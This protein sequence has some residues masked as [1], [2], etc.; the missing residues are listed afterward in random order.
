MCITKF[1]YF[2][3]SFDEL[4]SDSAPWSPT[5]QTSEMSIDSN[6]QMVDEPKKIYYSRE[7]C[8]HEAAATGGNG[9][10]GKLNTA[11]FSYKD[12]IRQKSARKKQEEAASR[13]K[14]EEDVSVIGTG[15]TSAKSIIS[16]I[17]GQNQYKNRSS[18]LESSSSTHTDT[19]TNRVIQ[20][21]ED[22]RR[23]SSP[24]VLDESGV[25]TASL[26]IPV[27]T[28]T[29]PFPLNLDEDI[30]YIDVFEQNGRQQLTI[31]HVKTPAAPPRRQRSI[32]GSDSSVASTVQPITRTQPLT[33]GSDSAFGSSI[34]VSSSMQN[35]P[36]SVSSGA[37]GG[38][39]SSTSSWAST[40]PTS[41]DNTQTLS[42]LP[43]DNL[44]LKTVKTQK[45]SSLATAQKVSFSATQELQQFKSKKS[46]KE[47][48][49]HKSQSAAALEQLKGASREP[50]FTPSITSIGN[51]VIRSKTA[52]FERLTKI[53]VQKPKTTIEKKKYTK[54][55]Y[56]E[57]RHPTKHIPDSEALEN[58]PMQS[59][60]EETST[61]SQTGSLYKRRE[62]ISSVPSK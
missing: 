32:S 41:P 47:Q 22:N 31:G 59:K 52:D 51:A 43:E 58:A 40:P 10:P 34:T 55:R 14:K 48:D 45:K 21:T 4:D 7:E 28:A 44:V 9:D 3:R 39:N 19:D 60:K 49:I 1:I 26:T 18:S 17:R 13:R 54:R 24:Y 23:K 15:I 16:K 2:F 29:Q 61:T 36:L 50:K 56:T 8:L 20:I 42:Y 46:T 38:L 30:P 57:S 27:Q 5:T 53:E 11:N 35:T 62:L 33:Q 6:F 12:R 25:I 37:D